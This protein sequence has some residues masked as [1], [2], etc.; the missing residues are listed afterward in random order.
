MNVT[1]D[2]TGLDIRLDSEQDTD[3]LGRALADLVVPDTVIGLVGPLGAGKT[4]L[5]RAIAEALKVPA[6]SVTSPTF[7]LIHEYEGTLPV[8]HFDAYRLRSGEEFEALGVDDYW[9]AGGV[10]LIEWADRVAD[11]LPAGTWFLTLEPT[12]P[13]SRRVRCAFPQGSPA[14]AQLIARL[15]ARSGE[16]SLGSAVR[17]GRSP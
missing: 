4:R 12:G 13:T 9:Q 5:V 11:R 15:N 1:W 2:A 10:C 3:T 14:T 16:E 17:P 7:V 6:D 8:L